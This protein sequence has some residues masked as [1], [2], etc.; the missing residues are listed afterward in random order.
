M[1]RPLDDMVL[2]LIP[3]VEPVIL[4]GGL[5]PTPEVMSQLS[6]AEW[7]WNLPGTAEDKIDVRQGVRHRLPQ[8]RAGLPQS[9]RRAQL[10][11]D[12]R[13][14]EDGR[15]G[16]ARARDGFRQSESGSVAQRRD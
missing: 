2:E 12:H 1:R 8:L 15:A 9:L 5:A 11:A 3:N 6:G 7:L 14:D 10:A 4:R 13:T 16:R